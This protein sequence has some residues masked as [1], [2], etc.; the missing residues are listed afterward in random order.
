MKYLHF[1]FLPAI[2][3]VPSPITSG[4]YSWGLISLLNDD[5][6]NDYFPREESEQ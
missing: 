2:I 6:P 1:S 5:L 4:W 3:K